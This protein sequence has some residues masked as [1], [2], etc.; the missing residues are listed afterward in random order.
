MLAVFRSLRSAKKN[1]GKE[2]GIGSVAKY[3]KEQKRKRWQLHLQ[4]VCGSKQTWELLAF[5]GRFDVRWLERALHAESDDASTPSN[6]RDEASHQHRLRLHHAKAEAIVRFKEGERLARHRASL[7]SRGAPQPAGC[8][9][10]LLLLTRRQAELLE[11]YSNDELRIARNRAIATLG[12]NQLHNRRGD[13]I[14]VVG[15]TGGVSG[16]II[17]GWRHPDFREFLEE[18]HE[19]WRL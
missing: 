4:Y 19:K 15:S 9:R 12:H 18:E 7:Q 14:D 10:Q 8:A 11:K 16:R 3:V 6:P 2:K 5:T 13:D 17:D 1:N